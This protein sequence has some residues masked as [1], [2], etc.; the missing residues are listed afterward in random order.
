[1]DPNETLKNLRE[2]VAEIISSKNNECINCNVI[3]IGEEFA[4][5]FQALDEWLS[6]GSSLPDDWTW[7]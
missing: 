3:N 6:E 2:L 4:E 7:D 5:Q 1:M